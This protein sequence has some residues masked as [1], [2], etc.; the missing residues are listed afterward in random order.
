MGD[1]P[2]GSQQTCETVYCSGP[3]RTREIIRYSYFIDMDHAMTAVSTT[4]C[5][6]EFGFVEG[7]RLEFRDGAG[8]SMS[9]G[10]LLTC[11]S[12]H[13]AA[14]CLAEWRISRHSH[15]CHVRWA[16]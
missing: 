9:S 2:L 6:M 1:V 5:P 7:T 10:E 15:L 4:W 16:V 11:A 14:R 3:S 13:P 8:A 12:A